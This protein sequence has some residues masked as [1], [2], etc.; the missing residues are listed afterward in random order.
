MH[1]IKVEVTYQ[2]ISILKGEG[3]KYYFPERITSFMRSNSR[4]PPIY[5]WDVFRDNPEDEKLIYIGEA[6]EL[7]SQQINGYLNPGPSRRTNELKKCFRA[8]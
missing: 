1:N 2:W 3:E 7:C 5:R 8:T 6:Q 4:Q